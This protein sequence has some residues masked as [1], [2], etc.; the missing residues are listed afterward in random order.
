LKRRNFYSHLA[1]DQHIPFDYQRD[2]IDALLQPMLRLS[3][4][5]E[6]L[7]Y[8]TS[9]RL[10][11]LS[12]VLVTQIFLITPAGMT[13]PSNGTLDIGFRAPHRYTTFDEDPDLLLLPY[14]KPGPCSH[15]WCL[16]FEKD[17]PS[18]VRLTP[19]CIVGTARI[20]FGSL[21]Q[22]VGRTCQC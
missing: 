4:A 11:L 6:L 7:G 20:G 10:V 12:G 3:S 19:E 15:Y 17:E 18:D 22:V 13:T 1:L 21:R 8:P 2:I 9:P 14:C 16:I 5:K